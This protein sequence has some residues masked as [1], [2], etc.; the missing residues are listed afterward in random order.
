MN[1]VLFPAPFMSTV[2]DLTIYSASNENGELKVEILEQLCTD[3]MKGDTFTS[4]VTL[5]LNAQ[6][7]M[8]CGNSLSSPWE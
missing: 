1:R 3:T 5:Y 2:G 4:T 8:G 7:F 6:T